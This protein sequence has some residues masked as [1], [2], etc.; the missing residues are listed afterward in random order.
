MTKKKYSSP[1]VMFEGGLTPEDD[2]TIVIGASQGTS[3]YDCR[4]EFDGIDEDILALI[5][6]NCD[7]FD[8]QNMDTDCDF[9]IT[10]AEFE[11]WFEQYQ[12]W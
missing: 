1:I 2:P 12:P 3:G 11:T 7:D 8:L 10:L 6:A 9:I 4:W 5:E